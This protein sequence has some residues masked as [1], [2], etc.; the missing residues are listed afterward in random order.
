MSATL[1]ESAVVALLPV[2]TFLC[3][4]V[5]LDSYKLVRLRSV[6]GLVVA[7][8]VAAGVGYV[9]NADLLPRSTL[10]LQT[11]TRYISPL[12]EELLKAVIVVVLIRTHRVGFLVDAAI[13]GFAIGTGFA[14]VENVYYLEH[15]HEASVGT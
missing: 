11:Y 15:V 13:F 6:V 8:A 7:G 3:V 10:Q 5:Y 1:L 2:L 12:V 14:M 4:L 9:V